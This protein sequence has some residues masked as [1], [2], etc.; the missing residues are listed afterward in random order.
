[1]EGLG[2]K[3]RGVWGFRLGGGEGVG[4]VSLLFYR[5]PYTAISLPNTY[6]VAGVKFPG[7]A[8]RKR[9]SRTLPP[10]HPFLAGQHCQVGSS[11]GK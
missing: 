8:E 9:L 11:V 10:P 2:G 6:I 5:Q 3:I 4:N 1:V 7:V